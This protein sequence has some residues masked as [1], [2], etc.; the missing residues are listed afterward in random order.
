MFGKPLRQLSTLEASNLIATLRD[1]EEGKISL[2]AVF[3][4]AAA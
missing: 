4:G 1:M 3:G 2:Q